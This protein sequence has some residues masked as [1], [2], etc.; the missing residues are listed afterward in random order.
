MAWNRKPKYR[1]VK[2]VI[3][4]ITFDSKKEAK[5]YTELAL[6]QKAKVISGLQLQVRYDIIIND[7]LVCFYKADFVYIEKGETVVE[8]VK[9]MLTPMYRLKKKLMKACHNIDIKET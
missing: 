7:Q 6:F 8:D 2:T 5:R 3:D 4:G 1:N 9:G